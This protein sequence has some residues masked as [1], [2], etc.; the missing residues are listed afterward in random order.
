MTTTG[1]RERKKVAAMRHVQDVAL[2]LYD[3]HGYDAVTVEQVAAAADVSPS[4]VYRWFGTKEQILLWDEYDPGLM[5]RFT[6][7]LGEHD[8]VEALQRAIAGAMAEVFDRDE[9]RVRRRLA[10]VVTEPPLRAANAEQMTGMA[11]WSAGILAAQVGREPDD[12]E[13]VIVADAL[14]A[15]LVAALRHWHATGY[16]E[17]L[18]E[19]FDRALAVLDRGCRLPG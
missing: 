12:L 2:N 11:Q 16:A 10:Y 5:Q 15:A 13:V 6:E 7:Q 9:R 4:S 14:V 18:T 1:L 17:P 3:M 19:V 8:P